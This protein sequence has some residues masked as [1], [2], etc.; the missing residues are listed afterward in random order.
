MKKG[1]TELVFV[2]DRSGSMSGLES[3]TIGGFNG[4]LKKHQALPGECCI[5]TLLFSTDFTW[6][7]DRINIQATNPLTD[8]DYQAMGGT[9]LVD[10]IGMAVEKIQEAQKHTNEDYQAEHVMFVI[11]TD[12]QENS[13]RRFSSDQVKSMIEEKKQ[14]G[15]EFIFLGANIDAVEVAS[16]YG[17]GADRA[18][19]YHADRMGTAVNFEA[20]SCAAE[21][22][23]SPQA[24]AIPD[25]W[26]AKVQ[27]DYAG[28]SSNR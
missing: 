23:R 10:A 24:P 2:I 5:T 22:L 28:R 9:A 18:Q 21:C 26:A 3:D 20:V 14:Q 12:G 15:W 27:A 8:Q 13:S 7:H 11:I 1:L 4:M 19:N 16:H 6:L 17:I 25:D